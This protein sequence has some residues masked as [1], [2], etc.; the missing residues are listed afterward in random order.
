M[1]KVSKTRERSNEKDQVEA[2][3]ELVQGDFE[4][5]TRLT[6]IQQLIPLGLMAVEEI[7]QEEVTHLAGEPYI[8]RSR[9]RWGS[10]PG[11]I[12][13]GDQKVA[14]AVPRARE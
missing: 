4:F 11:S 8:G 3:K 13:S 10:N 14:I 7:L 2:Y 1:K 9:Q 12:Y 6:L 5:T